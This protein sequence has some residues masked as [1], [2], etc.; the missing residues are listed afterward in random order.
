LTELAPTRVGRPRPSRNPLLTSTAPP[1]VVLGGGWTAVPVTRSLGE[2]GVPVYALGGSSDAVRWSRSCT[3]FVPL[4]H[5]AGMQDRWLEWLRGAPSGSVILPCGDEG[6]ELIA[7]NRTMLLELGLVPFEADDEVLLA[8]L[9]KARTYELARDMGIESPLTFNVHT[10][11][12]IA[13]ALERISYPCALKPVHS[14]AF[15]RHFAGMKAFRVHNDDDMRA[16]LARTVA[17]GIEMIVTEIIPGDDDQFF[18]YYTYMDEEGEPLLHATKRKLR[19]YPIWFGSGCFHVTDRNPEVAELGLRFFE[20]VGLRGLGNVEFKRDARDGRLKLIECNHRFT[21]AT[22]LM[23]AAGLDLPLFAYNRL[24]GRPLPPVDEYRPGKTMWYPMRDL[25][26][27]AAY[28]RQ[29]E[30]SLLPWLRSIMRRHHYPVASL[31]DPRPVLA[32]N[33]H[34]FGRIRRVLSR[35]RAQRQLPGQE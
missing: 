27:F 20:G 2:A 30:I 7:R 12:D 15:A 35:H 32:N 24:T 4:G 19:Q 16:A 9:D 33:L 5:E 14:H 26:A 6:L 10:Q 28:R 29:G 25:R 8:M 18:S 3:M 34:V 22:G 13:V 17:F 1:A 23:R 31:S 21:A 11:D